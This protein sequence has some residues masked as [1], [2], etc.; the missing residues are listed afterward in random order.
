[1]PK[2][3]KQGRIFHLEDGPN[4]SNHTQVP[5]VLVKDDVVRLYYACRNNG[6]AFVA[7]IDLDR[8]DLTRVMHVHEQPVFERGKPG[9]FDSDGVMPSCII[10]N[11][12]ELWL[13]YIGWNARAEGARYHNEIGIAVSTD[14][15]ETFERK[16]DG[17]VIGRSLTEP[18]LAVMPF[19]MFQNWFRMWYQSATGWEKIGDR[20][21]PVYVI[22]YADSVD[23]VN[24][25]RLPEQCVKSN[26]PL[27]AFSRPAVTFA[28]DTYHMWYCYRGSEDYRDGAGAY[29]IGYAQSKDGI[30]FL[31]CDALAGIDVGA[32]GE[33]D[34][35]QVCYP[36]VVKIDDRLIMFYNGNGFGQTGIGWAVYGD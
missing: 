36:A 3:Y 15:G 29:R 13:Y 19:V 8:R 17:P 11:H 30:N 26:F 10:E 9:M 31:R 35:K 32:E 23:G 2:W 5:T 12:G 24:W 21:E 33:W 28:G 20:Y 16:F 1:M 22:K 7:Y 14:G 34:S 6:K 25:N 4:R 18:G 27:E